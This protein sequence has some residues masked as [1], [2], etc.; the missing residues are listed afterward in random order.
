MN[1]AIRVGA[2][3]L[4]ATLAA[5]CASTNVEFGV[6]FVPVR[7]LHPNHLKIAVEAPGT[8]GWLV[9]EK[10]YE[11]G[12]RIAFRHE[13]HNDQ[14]RTRTVFLK[15][16]RGTYGMGV[17]AFE[18]PAQILGMNRKLRN[19]LYKGK[20]SQVIRRYLLQEGVPTSGPRR[21]P[22]WWCPFRSSAGSGSRVRGGSSAV[23]PV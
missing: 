2:C 1:V 20:G 16:D 15:A 23:V 21:T 14:S 11:A 4:L 17:E 12:W 7:D 13:D 3:I 6:K 18:E 9:N 8:E 19:Q 10:R 5:S 22:G